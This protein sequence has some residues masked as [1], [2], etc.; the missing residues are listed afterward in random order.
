MIAD[1]PAVAVTALAVD[2]VTEFDG[3]TA[4][5]DAALDVAAD[6][7][8]PLAVLTSIPSAIDRAT[9]EL[10]RDNGIAVLEGASSGLAALGHLAAWP[11][12][13]DHSNPG[14]DQARR[15]RWL[16]QTGRLDPSVAFDL[17]ADYGVRVARSRAAG[18]ME[19]TLAAGREIGHPVAM[20]TLGAEH[21]SDVGGVVLGIADEGSLRAEYTEMVQRLG[22]AVTVQPMI[23]EGV[24]I[25]VGVVRDPA[26]GPPLVVAGGGTL[27]ELLD[28]LTALADVIV[29]FSTMATELDD[30]IDALEA[31]PV[32]ASADGVVAVDA[33][34]VVRG[35]VGE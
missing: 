18:S 13:I 24:E 3:D 6:T 22:P 16:R 35:G 27:V 12:T 17:L 33:V 15:D 2:L 20:K 11:L 10:L 21:K 4:Y 28:D 31:N 34:L 25:S 8:A 26:F 1:D 23:A 32:I 30:A 29:A 9:A 14:V 19:E 5:A 7:G